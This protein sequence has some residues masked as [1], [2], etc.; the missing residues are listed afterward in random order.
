MLTTDAMKNVKKSQGHW[1]E[2]Y[3]SVLFSEGEVTEESK[4]KRLMELGLEVNDDL[5]LDKLINNKFVD[6]RG[7]IEEVS[8]KA[9]K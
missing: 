7:I 2:I 1:N 4:K 8:K 6:F 9:D 3:N 5:S